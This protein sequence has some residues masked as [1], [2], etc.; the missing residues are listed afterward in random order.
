MFFLQWFIYTSLILSVVADLLIAG[1]LCVLLSQ[2]RSGFARYV[3]K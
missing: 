1:S 3:F 2:R